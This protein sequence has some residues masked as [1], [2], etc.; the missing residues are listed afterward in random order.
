MALGVIVAAAGPSAW[1][2]EVPPALELAVPGPLGVTPTPED[3]RGPVDPVSLPCL[4]VL[5]GSVS[6]CESHGLGRVALGMLILFH[7]G[8]QRAGN[9]Y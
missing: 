8:P 6:I 9:P 1:P 2:H 7:E 5:L 4:A 3:Y